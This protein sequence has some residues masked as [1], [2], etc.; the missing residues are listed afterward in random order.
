MRRLIRRKY[1]A[2]EADKL[3]E[4]AEPSVASETKIS[5]RDRP[6]FMSQTTVMKSC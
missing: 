5:L 6:K 3:V 1:P 4:G 2:L